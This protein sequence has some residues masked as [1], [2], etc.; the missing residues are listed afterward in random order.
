MTF[1]QYVDDAGIAWTIRIDK[2]NSQAVVTGQSSPLCPARSANYP[3]F[4]G[5]NGL[6]SIY[7]YCVQAPAIKR[8]FTVGDPTLVAA[9]L[10]SGTVSARIYPQGSAA[11]PVN[12]EWVVTSY[13]GH[14]QKLPPPI[15]GDDTGLNDGTI[16]Q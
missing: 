6:R 3:L 16:E 11:V 8:R 2:S 10:A 7:A 12:G 5:V 13:R 4:K 14:S 1:R 15:L 9:I